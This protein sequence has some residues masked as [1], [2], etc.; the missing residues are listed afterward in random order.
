MK[1]LSILGI[2]I[3]IIGILV[4]I[5]TFNIWSGTWGGASHSGKIPGTISIIISVYFL[6]FSIL[7][8]IN[9]FKK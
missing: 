3:S 7:S 9:S 5:F 2:I 8:T 6:F 4:G 1:I